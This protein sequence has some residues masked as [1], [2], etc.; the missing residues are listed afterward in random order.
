MLPQ[1]KFIAASATTTSE[2]KIIIPPILQ[3]K[4]GIMTLMHDHPTAGHLG[5]N[6]TLW[7]I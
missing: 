3:V 6:E 7:K 1:H 5:H 2:G 4:Q